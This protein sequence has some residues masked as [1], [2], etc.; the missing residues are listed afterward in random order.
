LAKFLGLSTSVPLVCPH[1]P[2]QHRVCGVRTSI[3]IEVEALR[4]EIGI[5]IQA[6][7]RVMSEM[8]EWRDELVGG[9]S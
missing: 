9:N 3:K 5:L 4:G 8:I 7:V 1:Q 6:A 2:C